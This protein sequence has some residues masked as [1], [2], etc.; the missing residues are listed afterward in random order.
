MPHPVEGTCPRC[1]RPAA[2]L[3]PLAP[4]LRWPAVV[5]MSFLHAG[6]WTGEA[7]KA[8]LCP[9]CRLKAAVVSAGVA[10]AAAAAVVL[11]ARFLL[12]AGRF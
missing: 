11:G 8:P 10:A 9:S 7:L 1:G 5:A 2:D 12:L 4:L 3:R 6:L